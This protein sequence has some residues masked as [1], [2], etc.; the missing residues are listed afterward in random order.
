MAEQKKKRWPS[1]EAFINRKSKEEDV[2][3]SISLIA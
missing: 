1:I 3:G 2:A